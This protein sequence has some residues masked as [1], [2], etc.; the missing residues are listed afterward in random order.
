MQRD[1]IERGLDFV[2]EAKKRISSSPPP[3]I[4]ST[5]SITQT[6][7]FSFQPLM[8]ELALWEKYLTGRLDSAETW[9]VFRETFRRAATGK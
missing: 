7:G 6:L 5:S 9:G 2:D 4:S 3:L 8:T 1:A